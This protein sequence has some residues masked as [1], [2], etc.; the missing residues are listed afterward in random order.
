VLGAV[1]L[2][3]G[4]QATKKIEYVLIESGKI[5]ANLQ[6]E[7]GKFCT[8]RRSA[9]SAHRRAGERV[10]GLRTAGH[11]HSSIAGTLANERQLT[12]TIDLDARFAV[13]SSEDRPP[14]LDP[15]RSLV[16]DRS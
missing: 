4:G 3:K 13:M 8:Y 9:V 6:P 16:S 11:R 14:R 2:S 10:G 15:E 12:G 7:D 1:R 5:G